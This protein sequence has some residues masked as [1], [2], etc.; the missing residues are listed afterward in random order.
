[1]VMI[2]MGYRWTTNW[3]E[4]LFSLL[5]NQHLPNLIECS[6]QLTVHWQ[7]H[8]CVAF[9]ILTIHLMSHV[10]VSFCCLLVSV[11]IRKHVEVAIIGCIKET[12]HLRGCPWVGSFS[13][14]NHGH[15]CKRA[16]KVKRKALEDVK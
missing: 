12:W 2:W 5:C 9:G 8:H 14:L 6:V 16:S 13:L 1:M 7:H 11:R 4:N 10:G 3:T 15:L